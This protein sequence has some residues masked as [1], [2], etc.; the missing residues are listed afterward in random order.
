[1]N[2]KTSSPA[3]GTRPPP[4]VRPPG[5]PASLVFAPDP[6]EV[7]RRAYFTFLNHGSP[8]GHDVQH[9]LTAEAEMIAERNQTRVHG[10]HNPT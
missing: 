9:W 8:M 4:A 6:D 5:D 1:M 2:H 7:A 10:Y 3:P